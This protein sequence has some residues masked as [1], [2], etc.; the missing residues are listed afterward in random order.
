MK[1]I[2]LIGAGG[3][4]KSCIDIIEQGNEYSINGLIDLK[5]NIGSLVLGYKII[6]CDENL[7][8]YVQPDMYFLITIGQIKSSERREALFNFLKNACANLATI[9]S[10]YAY[11]SKHAKIDEG[12]II[13]H[14]AIINANASVGKN[15]IINSKALVE[16]DAIIEDNCHLSTCSVVNGQAVIKRGSFIGSNAVVVHNVTVKENSF[17]KAKS[18]VK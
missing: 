15:C 2:I 12:T 11:V 5:E 4:A 18:L 3:H 9:I 13:M 1:D 10:P 17:I 6:D 7:L 16:H 8:N 14:G